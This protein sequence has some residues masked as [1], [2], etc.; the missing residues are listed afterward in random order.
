MC[1]HIDKADKMVYNQKV[2]NRNSMQRYRS[3]HN[4]G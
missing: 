1:R 3:G 4:G 2:A